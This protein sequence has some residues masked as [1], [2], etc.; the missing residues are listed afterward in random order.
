MMKIE[1]MLKRV[2]DKADAMRLDCTNIMDVIEAREYDDVY[3]L[4]MFI[5]SIINC[6]EE[7]KDIIMQMYDEVEE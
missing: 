6:A 2:Q 1:K 4:E 5:N 3:N 7:A